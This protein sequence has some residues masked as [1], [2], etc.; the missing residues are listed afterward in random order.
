[1]PAPRV[2]VLYNEPTL[3]ADHPDAEAE[4]D[5]LALTDVVAR[6][7]QST[8]ATV[9]RLGVVDSAEAV[10]N[11]VLSFRPDV[12]FNLYEGTAAWGNAEA[13]VAGILD[14]M[15]VP[16]TGSGPQAMM[17]A[18]SKPLS[19]A[20]FQ[21]TGV[22]TAPYFVVSGEA[23]P[24]N[25]LGW[26][27]IVKPAREDA[28]VGIDQ[29]SVCT[30]PTELSARVRYVQS[31]YGPGAIVERLIVGREL[32]AAVIDTPDGL[33]TLPLTEIFFPTPADGLPIWPIV[34]YDAKWRE[35]SRDYVSTPYKNP[36]DV[37]PGLA[38]RIDDLAG[39]AFDIIGCRDY[40]RIDFRVD[41]AGH[42][43]VLE[44]NPNPCIAPGAGVAESLAS[45]RIPYPDFITG[46]VRRALRRSQRPELADELGPV[47]VS[48]PETRAD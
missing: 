17:V 40:A 45:A 22:P 25:S 28:S 20:L 19:K 27:V 38:R 16:Y 12:V 32:H 5:V 9:G 13:Y 23:C 26:P 36:A 39:R 30:T 43:F 10:V 37:S 2:L 7:L 47:S 21:G 33:R 24:E 3:P 42:P 48:V 4:H 18:R 6:T 46:L 8:A 29:K 41:E 34:T 1:M 15:R 35:G 31:T 11:G 44:V 14:L